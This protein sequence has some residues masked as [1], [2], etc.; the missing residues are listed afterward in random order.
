MDVVHYMASKQ[1]YHCCSKVTDHEF[2]W[3]RPI[4]VNRDA[5]EDRILDMIEHEDDTVDDRLFFQ[6]YRDD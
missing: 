1:H 5:E 6:G 4:T 2:Y 3:P